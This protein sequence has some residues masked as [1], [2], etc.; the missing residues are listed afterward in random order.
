[1][2][3]IAFVGGVLQLWWYATYGDGKQLPRAD[4]GSVSGGVEG[5]VVPLLKTESSSVY[6]NAEAE[7]NT[8][9][10]KEETEGEQDNEQEYTQLGLLKDLNMLFLCIITVVCSKLWLR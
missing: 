1:M 3:A 9:K 2:A 5:L 4:R 10:A 6:G 7:E 8:S